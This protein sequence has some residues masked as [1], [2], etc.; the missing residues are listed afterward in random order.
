MKSPLTLHCPNIIVDDPTN[1]SILTRIVMSFAD[2][3]V[4][5]SMYSLSIDCTRLFTREIARKLFGL[6]AYTVG[7]YHPLHQGMHIDPIGAERVHFHFGFN[8]TTSNP[9]PMLA[10]MYRYVAAL[11]ERFQTKTDSFPSHCPD[12]VLAPK[13]LQQ[14][15]KTVHQ[16]I[17]REGP[18]G[19]VQ[20]IQATVDDASHDVINH[21]N[22]VPP[23]PS[24]TADIPLKHRVLRYFLRHPEMLV[25]GALAL[26]AV[27]SICVYKLCPN[28]APKPH[29]RAGAGVNQRS[30][31]RLFQPR[32]VNANNKRTVK[33]STLRRRRTFA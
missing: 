14:L 19:S 10:G 7:E 26:T 6:N 33:L 20:Y 25:I 1:S 29:H 8:F 32:L 16:C 27:V 23:L 22:Q 4:K 5:L 2:T 30:A 17:N 28:D 9:Q 3:V 24:N 21:L 13:A 12:Y 11:E 18:S 31:A 15:Q